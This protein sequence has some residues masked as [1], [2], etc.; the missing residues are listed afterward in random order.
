MKSGAGSAEQENAI[1][2]SNKQ[3]GNGFNL[4]LIKK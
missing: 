3:L 1:I 4:R 2:E